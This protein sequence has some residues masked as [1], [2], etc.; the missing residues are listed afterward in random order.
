MKRL[1]SILL[2]I[3]IL[4]TLTSFAFAADAMTD[5]T[6]DITV[7]AFSPEFPDAYL[8]YGGP[9]PALQSSSVPSESPL[10]TITVT[11]FVQ[12]PIIQKLAKPFIVV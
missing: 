3:A 10:G 6:D 2:S 8:E 9:A 11:A 1:F 4:C 5:S 12:K 7:A